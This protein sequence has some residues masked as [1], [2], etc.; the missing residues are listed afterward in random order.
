MPFVRENS[1]PMEDDVVITPNLRRSPKERRDFVALRVRAGK[2]NR[3]IAKE[4]GVDEGTIRRDRKYLAT[5]EHERP[6][7]KP[8]P[9][10]SAKPRL[11]K[12]V[13]PA[14]LRVRHFQTMLKTIKRWL[15][16]QNPILPDIDYVLHEAGRRVYEGQVF[17]SQLM[18]PTH[19]PVELL[20]MARPNRQVEDYMPDRLEYCADWLARWLASCLPCDEAGRDELLRKTSIWARST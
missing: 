16:E 9:P 3:A 17:I 6:A 12:E 14:E 1:S 2:S 10:K 7:K 20:S 4:L 11:V 8:R 18:E 13:D 15:S 5:P 19:G